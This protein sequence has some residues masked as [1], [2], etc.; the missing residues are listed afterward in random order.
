VKQFTIGTL[1]LWCR[2]TFHPLSEWQDQR[3]HGRNQSSD[4]SISM[5]SWSAD[6]L[7]FK[8]AASLLVGPDKRPITSF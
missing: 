3:V 4:R 7:V 8:E 1:K 2:R 6:G 5:S